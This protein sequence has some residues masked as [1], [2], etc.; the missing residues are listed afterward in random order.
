MINLIAGSFAAVGKAQ[1]ASLLA[2]MHSMQLAARTTTR[3]WGG[4]PQPVLEPL[5]RRF[6]DS[7]WRD[8]PFADVLK[9]SYLITEQWVE[10][11]ADSL[12]PIN[13]ILHKR[14][15]FWT[16]Q[17]TDALSPSNFI[18]TNPVVMQEIVRTGGT[19]L[20]RGMQNLAADIRRGRISQVPVD[21]FQVGKDLAITPGK[22]IYRNPL[23]ELIQYQPSTPQVYSIPLLAIPP[24][25]NKFYVMDLRPENS[26]YKHLVDAG[27]T[28]FGLSWKNPDQSVL[29]MTWDDY[30]ERG[31]LEALRVV[32]SI[33]G[34][35]QVNTF[36]YCL[37][38]IILQTALAYNTKIDDPTI[39]SATFFTTH[40]DFS[41]AGDITV[42]IDDLQVNFLEWLMRA[43]G[44]YLDG[45]NMAATFNMLRANDLL[46]NY[47]VQNYLLGK[48]PPSFDLLYWNNDGTRVPAKVHSF[49]LREMFL[50]NKLKD[51]NA[52]QI[53]G[54][55]GRHGI[56][57]SQI[58]TPAYVVAADSDHIVPWEGAYLARSLM[59]GPVRFILTTGGHIAGIIN[60]PAKS[61]REYWTNEEITREP[62]VWLSHATNHKGSWWVDWFPWLKQYSGDLVASPGMGSPEYP[63][64]GDAPGMYVLEK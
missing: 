48:H 62:K 14:A 16:R 2:L 20:V 4:E 45:R 10:D 56:D 61:R 47:V 28:L 58:T 35:A 41:F 25:I 31:I 11:L 60:P 51:P 7:A 1:Q 49:L 39:H 12:E 3:F 9:Q 13:P 30:V 44:G 64:L 52:I 36:G 5:D 27:F 55:A 22:V 50:K 42:F 37:G 34:S 38:G 29:D 6:E 19:N 18:V 8:N 21:S 57:L 17:I 46:W 32:K 54:Q 26:L 63:T 59:S 33:T 53:T 43:S 40:Q 24:W 15:K 23:I